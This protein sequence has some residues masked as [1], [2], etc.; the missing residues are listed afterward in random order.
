M[1]NETSKF[2]NQLYL[3]FLWSYTYIRLEILTTYK[4]TL[5]KT[6]TAKLDVIIYEESKE[7]SIRS[8]LKISNMRYK[9]Y[10]DSV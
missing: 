9:M 6:C 2:T 3:Y 4:V 8:S 7:L 5:C 1:Y 10:F